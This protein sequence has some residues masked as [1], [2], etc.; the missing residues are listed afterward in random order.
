MRGRAN[1]RKLQQLATMVAPEWQEVCIKA[2][3]EITRLRK[4]QRLMQHWLC[5][6]RVIDCGRHGRAEPA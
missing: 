2:A 1:T 5:R 3:D 4:R 6:D